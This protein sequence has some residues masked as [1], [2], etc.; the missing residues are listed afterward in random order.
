[1]INNYHLP[2]KNASFRLV[3]WHGHLWGGRFRMAVIG[4]RQVTGA[5][6]R[7]PQTEKLINVLS[8]Q[9]GTIGLLLA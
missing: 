7:N 4:E 2:R 9:F 6:G 1:M 5:N 3:I 8:G